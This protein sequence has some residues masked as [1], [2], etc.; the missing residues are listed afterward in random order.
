MGSEIYIPRDTITL[1]TLINSH[2]G[3]NI[4][5]NKHDNAEFYMLQ[6]FRA[7]FVKLCKMFCKLSMYLFKVN[8]TTTTTKLFFHSHI[9]ISC[10]NLWIKNQGKVSRIM[11][12]P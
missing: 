1:T 4:T 12:K 6:L 5:I 11:S 3:T 7:L 2:C 10:Y 8:T 9:F